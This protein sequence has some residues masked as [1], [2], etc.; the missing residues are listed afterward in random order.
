[1]KAHKPERSFL[2]GRRT[3]FFVGGRKMVNGAVRGHGS[4]QKSEI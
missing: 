4:L 3:D 1:M 2:C